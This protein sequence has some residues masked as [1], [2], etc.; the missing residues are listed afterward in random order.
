MSSAKIA[1]KQ[2]HGAI[3]ETPLKLGPRDVPFVSPEKSAPNLIFFPENVSTQPPLS[4]IL[5]D[6]DTRSP[7]LLYKATMKCIGFGCG[8]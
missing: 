1:P 2:G 8:P 3:N 5:V 6:E 4:N 7:V